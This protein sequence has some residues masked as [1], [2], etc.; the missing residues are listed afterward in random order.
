MGKENL[1]NQLVLSQEEPEGAGRRPAG[2]FSLEQEREEIARGN[3]VLLAMFE[4][5]KRSTYKTNRECFNQLVRFLADCARL[6]PMP[7]ADHR[8]ADRLLP[9]VKDYIEACGDRPY[10]YLG[11]LFTAKEC[12]NES[13][14]QIITPP[15]LVS[16]INKATIGE[17]KDDER[18][19]LVLDP[20]VGTGRFLVDAA[21]RYRDR[22][23]AL[24]GV[25]LDIDLYRACLVN[26][27]FFAWGLPYYILRANALMVDL[28]PESP[29]WRFANLW[30]P[31][32]WETGMLMEEDITFEEWRRKHGKVV[33]TPPL[34]Q[35][36]GEPP[37]K[38]VEGEG[39][40]QP[41]L[42]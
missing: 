33:S 10:D 3:Q 18:W 5:V 25:E 2:S 27:R 39:S 30:D 23:L 1:N 19:K 11:D 22:K 13:L 17:I 28:R 38:G 20:C 8:V 36:G 9:L 31:P 41:K 15:W 32:D 21:V 42:F 37:A 16:Y 7:E 26:M 24:Y 34:S 29:N 4:V 35:E 12:A 40:L 6:H 14:G